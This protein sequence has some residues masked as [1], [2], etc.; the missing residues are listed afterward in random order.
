MKGMIAREIQ[1]LKDKGEDYSLLESCLKDNP[2][3]RLVKHAKE[4]GERLKEL[5]GDQAMGRML[6]IDAEAVESCFLQTEL[7][8]T[9]TKFTEMIKK[10]C[11]FSRFN[12][13]VEKTFIQLSM[14]QRPV[15]CIRRTKDGF[16]CGDQV[17]SSLDTLER[18][19][20][21]Q[22]FRILTA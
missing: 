3:E 7:D 17:I 19:V 15:L 22:L 6:L 1:R 5:P 8:K 9:W 10:Y 16:E 4:I 12:Y 11:R 21:Y 20:A 13:H 14:D 2:V 18:F